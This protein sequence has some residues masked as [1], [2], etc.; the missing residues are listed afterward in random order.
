MGGLPLLVSLKDLLK[1]VN[2][3]DMKH[4]FN[5]CCSY[6]LLNSVFCMITSIDLTEAKIW[7]SVSSQQHKAMYQM[8]VFY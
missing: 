4:L 2:N 1:K 8:L 3:R 5:T 7:F 6:K